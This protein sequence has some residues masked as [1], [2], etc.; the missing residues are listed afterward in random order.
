MAHL[1]RRKCIYCLIDSVGVPQPFGK[2]NFIPILY[3]FPDEFH[4]KDLN[5]KAL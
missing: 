4:I 1:I 3:F 5:E 2:E